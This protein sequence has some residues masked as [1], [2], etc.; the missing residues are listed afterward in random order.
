MHAGDATA[1]DA[2]ND[3]T[4][5]YIVL[6]GNACAHDLTGQDLGGLTLT[7][8]VYCFSS[9]AQLTGKLV[10][11]AQGD[12]SAVF[13]F[14]IGSSLT[15]ASGASVVF[16]NGGQDCAAF[17]QI[18]SSATLGTDTVFAGSMLALTSITLDTRASVSG[19]ALARNGAV[20]MDTNHVFAGACADT[21]SDAG[22][23]GG[24]AGVGGSDAGVGGSGGTGGSGGCGAGP[25]GGC[26][27]GLGGFGASGGCGGAAIDAG[28]GGIES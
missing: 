18:G 4:A 25:S 8:G 19:R 2:Q 9:S 26:G 15:T 28:L 6:A 12:P 23:G 11:D 22:V 13:I 14:Q 20:T 17:W 1:L 16:T 3:V 10:L 5:A 21:G 7:Q 24:D 27:A